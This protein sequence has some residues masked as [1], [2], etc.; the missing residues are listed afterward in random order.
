MKTLLTYNFILFLFFLLSN[1]SN[2]ALLGTNN[3]AVNSNCPMKW[4]KS[5]V[6]K[7]Y[8]KLEKI[9]KKIICLLGIY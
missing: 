6:Y 9:G 5:G 1:K 4:G 8:E 7:L 3:N 2:G